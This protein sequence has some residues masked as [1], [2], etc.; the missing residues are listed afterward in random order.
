[1]NA[2]DGKKS[3]GRKPATARRNPFNFSILA[4]ASGLCCHALGSAIPATALAGSGTCAGIDAGGDGDLAACIVNQLCVEG[5]YDPPRSV[6]L[7]EA[8]VAAYR[9]AEMDIEVRHFR[10]EVRFR[11]RAGADIGQCGYTGPTR[12]MYSLVEPAGPTTLTVTFDP[13][14]TY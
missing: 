1:M 11:K 7:P 4:A 3:A 9:N 10:L 2:V 14:W 6:D 12:F 13:A 5:I 8:A